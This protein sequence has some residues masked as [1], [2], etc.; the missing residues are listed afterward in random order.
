[1]TQFMQPKR[2]IAVCMI[3]LTVTAAIAAGSDDPFL[4]LACGSV[5]AAAVGLLWR[6]G[7]GSALLMA[8]GLQLSQ[9]VIRPVHASL[10]GL[11]LKDVSYFGDI[12]L[13]TW[14][15]LAAIM[16]LVIGMYIGQLGTKS[17]ASVMQLE[18]RSWTPRA[19]FV[20][21]LVTLLLSTTVMMVGRLDSGL[22]QPALAASRIE[23]VGVFVLVYVCTVQRR[24]FAFV[25]FVLFLELVKTVGGYFADF[26][27]VFVVIL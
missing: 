26:K 21:C 10:N 12:T 8:A 6:T 1:M 15:A 19:A 23:W 4:T 25:M 27:D 7:E 2:P 17:S 13:A 5:V 3:I 16:S 11:S 18:A 24:G 22:Q 9:V 14:F 20:F